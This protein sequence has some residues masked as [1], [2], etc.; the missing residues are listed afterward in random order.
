MANDESRDVRKVSLINLQVDETTLPHL[1]VRTRE[2]DS[3]I[4]M[5]VYRK[6][7]KEKIP[8]ANLKLCEIYKV[9]YDGLY[10]REQGVKDACVK[11]LKGN[12]EMF[13]DKDEAVEEENEEE[14]EEATGRGRRRSKKGS[15]KD[16]KDVYQKTKLDILR[17]MKIFQLE[18]TLIHPHLYDLMDVVVQHLVHDIIPPEEMQA[19][20]REFIRV[21]CK[22]NS[23]SK[24]EPEEVFFFRSLCTYIQNNPKEFGDLISIIDDN[25]LSLAEFSKVLEKNMRNKDLLYV[26]QLLLIA[27]MTLNLDETGR[28]SLVSVLKS[29]CLDLDNHLVLDL[30]DLHG[31]DDDEYNDIFPKKTEEEIVL[32]QYS[33]S[34]FD[35]PIVQNTNDLIPI[36]IGTLRKLLDD[37]NNAFTNFVLETISEIKETIERD[38]DDNRNELLSQK[39]KFQK[40]IELVE[41]ELRQ[42]DEEASGKKKG[43]K[44]LDLN[45]AEKEKKKLESDKKNYMKKIDEINEQINRTTIRCLYIACSLLQTCRISLSDPGNF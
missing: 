8:L 42:M 26:Y 22:Q 21:E 23:M 38:V 35:T 17:F 3:E 44:K 15:G 25:F 24:L 39:D 4:R 14:E 40:Q 16:K 9:V 10:A 43:N 18:K 5:L 12:Y 33:A 2:M 13:A 30:T 41:E 37:S 36:C 20:L 34:F 1:L 29:F 19:Y 31:F 27:D 7:T 28:Q 32:Q 11:Y 45:K 6:L